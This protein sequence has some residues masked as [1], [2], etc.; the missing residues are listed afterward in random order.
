V[1]VHPSLDLVAVSIEGEEVTDPGTVQ[2]FSVD[3]ESLGEAIEVG[4]LPD[5]I[6]WTPNGEKLLVANEAEPSDDYTVDPEGSVSIITLGAGVETAGFDG[7]PIDAEVRIF[8]PDASAAQ[9]LE[10]EY[11]AVSDDS[12][13][14]WVTL[15]E[16][17]AVAKL[18][19]DNAQFEWVRSLGYKDHSAEGNGLD[20]SNKDKA[21]S[22][23]SW[24][25]LGMYQPD[26]VGTYVIDGQRYLITANEGDAREYTY[27]IDGDEIVAF[28]E[29]ARVADL[30]LDPVAFPDWEEL[31]DKENLGRL[32]VTTSFP[33]EEGPDGYAELYS[34]GARSFT[35]WTDEGELVFDSGNEFEK[36]LAYTYPEFFNTTDDEHKFDSRSDDKGPEPE[37]VVL[38]KIGD[39]TI[40]FVGLERMG[41]I[42]AYDVSDPQNPRFLDYVNNRNFKVDPE[43]DDDVTNR[44]VRDLG[45][46]GLIFIPA[47]KSPMDQSLVVASNEISGTTTIFI[48][49]TRGIEP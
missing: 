3:G 11:I 22:I 24:P 36:I 47:D 30:I 48:V 8:G 23:R 21:I 19:I 31:Q 42:M 18:D 27:E 4:S 16:N 20:A 34:F 12:S 46:E 9:D 43:V 45:T 29:E 49:V 41:G 38:G 10:P 26:A 35:I 15:Q 44:K 6:V 1:A 14:A 5:M 37:H 33:A 32:K 39:S 17:N 2:F 7:V 28:S 13:T 40:A 25:V